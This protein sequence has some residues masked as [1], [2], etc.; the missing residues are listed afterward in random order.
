MACDVFYIIGKLLEIRCLKWACIV[1]WISE[2][3]V[4]AKRRTRSQTSNL[5]PDH[6]KSR[7]D[8][9]YFSAEGVRHTFGKLL[10]RATTLL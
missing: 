7:V 4:M 9:I 5:T 6:K 2:T 10:R 1:I 8:S 3:Q